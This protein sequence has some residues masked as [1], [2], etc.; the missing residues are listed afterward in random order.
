MGANFQ[1]MTVVGTLTRNEVKDAFSKAQDQDLYENGHSY[2]GG[3]GMTTGLTFAD[4][5]FDLYTDAESWLEENCS[6]WEDAKVVTFTR[7]G[8]AHWLIGAWCS[9]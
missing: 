6:K 3:F 1:T 7:N 8:A 4:E 9:S 2:S 5:T